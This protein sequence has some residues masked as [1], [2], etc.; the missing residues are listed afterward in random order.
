MAVAA[1]AFLVAD[2]LVHG[3]AQRDAD[4]FHRVVGVDVQV[5]GGVDVEVDQA[6]PGDLIEH[7]IEERHA[8]LEAGLAGAVQIQA[9][10]DLGFGGAAGYGGGAV[11]HRSGK[12]LYQ[13]K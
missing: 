12:T 8:G 1:D 13:H 10:A 7:V 5:A 9:D 11:G 4:I 6:V 2:R 3:L